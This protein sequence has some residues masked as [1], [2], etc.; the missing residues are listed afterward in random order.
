M[1]KI[2]VALLSVLIMFFMPLADALAESEKVMYLGV[3]NGQVKGN[4]VVEASR[5]LPNPELYKASDPAALPDEL[6]IRHS[7][8]RAGS[9]GTLYLMVRQT[10]PDVQPDAT[11]T[12]KVTLWI[13]GKKAPA[14]F[15]QQGTDVLIDVPSAQKQVEL[16]SDT[17]M[18]LLVPANYRGELRVAMN[19]EGW[20]K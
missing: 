9:D 6:R 14:I 13:D 19:I 1:Q 11:A 12:V 4:Q 5:T 18:Q 10:I 8:A 15:T 17:P 2:S 20:Q 7:T 3:V 16:R